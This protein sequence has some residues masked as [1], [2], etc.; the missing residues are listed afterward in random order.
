[1]SESTYRAELTA[2]QQTKDQVLRGESGWL[3]V[4]GLGWLREGINTI[5]SDPA[6]DIALPAA[7]PGHVGTL[8]LAGGEVTFQPAAAGVQINGAPAGPTVLRNDTHAESFDLVSF[9]G[10]TFFIIQRGQRFGVRIRD[11]DAPARREFAGRRWFPIDERYRVAATLVAYDFPKPIA[12]TNIL[13]DTVSEAS[14]GYVTFALDGQ[15]LQLDVVSRDH[16]Q[17]FFVFRDRSGPE[18]SYPIRFLEA[19][20][21]DDGTV[22]LDFNRAYN[23]PC[24]FTPHATCPLPPPQNHLPVSIEAGER[25]T[26]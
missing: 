4:V 14:P 2:W 13:G 19:R 5:G 15:Q 9:D 6:S 22:D 8:E 1:M 18:L 11:A 25:T 24:A 16:D 3:T 21:L 17:L 23:A 10:I 26:E 20:L 12:V 7:A